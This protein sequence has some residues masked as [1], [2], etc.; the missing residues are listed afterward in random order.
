M[1]ESPDEP[2]RSDG[3]VVSDDVYASEEVGEQYR[4][5]V[6]RE[7]DYDD[8]ETA[9][10]TAEYPKRGRL[11]PFKEADLPKVPKVSHIVG[12]SAIMLGASLGSGETMFW[13]TLIAQYGWTLYWAF[14]V[15]VLTQFF[16]NTELQRWTM[17]TGESIFRGYDRINGVWPWFFLAA[18]FFHLG[19]PGWAA[20]GAQVLANWAGLANPSEQWWIIGVASMVV[21]WLS[22]MAGPVLY[23]VIEKI[24]IVLMALAI[25]FAVVLI[26]VVGSAGELVNVPSGAVSFGALP[27]QNEL[28]IATFLGGLAYAGAGGY[29][30]LSQGVWSREKG[31]GMGTYQGRVKNPLRGATPE[32]IYDGFAFEPTET[33]LRRWRGWW[34]VTQREHFLTFVIG[35]LVVATVAM[36]ITAQYVPPGT[37]V[38]DD[39]IGMWV[40]VI[41]PQLD[42]LTATLLYAVIFIALFS[43]QYAIVESFVRNSVDILYQGYGRTHGWD[44][45]RVFLGLLTL[46]TLW[47]IAIIFATGTM[48]LGQ[49]WILLVIGAAIA[50]VMM[51]PYNALTVIL[52]TTHLPEHTQ[53]GWARVVAMW[54]A[55]GFFGFFSVLLIGAQLSGPVGLSAFSTSINVV[56]S[57][58]GG[59][60]LWLFALVVQVYTMYVS[61]RAKLNASGTVTDAEEASGFLS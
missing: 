46:F 13:P 36:T 3:G 55:T 39:A 25:V 24:Q 41:I 9:P 1:T 47:G 48:G 29:I 22:Y 28:D 10:Q 49:P 45:S 54:W 50:G 51:W 32:R 27:P 37:N 26:F 58:L 57:G 34:K 16:I 8:L 12:P 33:N 14:W 20:G 15:G 23:N 19:W 31:Y 44:L 38:V 43:T 56:D 7:L 42:G 53:P 18:G 11:E 21:I 60:L 2:T 35:L 40:N 61:A 52:N 30:N 17:A 5:T 6:Y 4:D 59:Y